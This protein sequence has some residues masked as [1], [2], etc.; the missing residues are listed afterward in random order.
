M[1]MHGDAA[2]TGQGSVYETLM[3]SELPAFTTGGT[4]HIIVNN[5]IGFTTDPADYRVARFPSDVAR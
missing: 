3:L 4:I 2:F 5:Q 1:L